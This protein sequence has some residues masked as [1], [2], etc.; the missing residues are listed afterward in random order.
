MP[1]DATPTDAAK[2]PSPLALVAL[3]LL[4][5]IRI[6]EQPLT[7]IGAIGALLI[8]IGVM[9]GRF[10]K[11]TGWERR[12]LP[13]SLSVVLWLSAAAVAVVIPFVM[14]ASQPTLRSTYTPDQFATAP[15]IASQRGFYG[16]ESDPAGNRYAWTQG[17]ARLVF[18]FLVH[19][20]ITIT[21]DARSAAIAGGPDVPV[22]VQVNGEDVGEFRPDPKNGAFQPFSLTFVPYDWGGQRSEIKLAPQQS[23]TPSKTD[24]R[25]LGTMIARITIDKSEA[26]STVARRIWLVWALPVL[27]A[28]A[29]ALVWAARRGRGALAGYGAIAACLLGVGCAA[30]ALFLLFRVGF[31]EQRTYLVWSLGGAF[32][33]GCFAAAALALPLGGPEAASVLQR[34]RARIARSRLGRYGARLKA[35]AALPP[36]AADERPATGRL[37]VRDLLVLFVVAFGLRCVWAVVVPPW[38]APDEPDQFTYVTHLAEQH[39]IPHAPYPNYPAYSKENTT[40]WDLTLLTR[41]SSLGSS[42]THALP[43]YPIAYNYQDARIYRG[44][45]QDRRSAAAGRASSNPPLYYLYSTPVYLLFNGAPILSRLFAVRIGSAVLGALSCVFGY[46]LAYELRRTRRWGW[47]LGLCMALMPM[48]V[49]ITSTVNNDVAM[50]ACAAALIWLTARVYRRRTFS[51]RLALAL[52]ITSGLT[53]LTK[54]TVAPVVA[55][56]GIVVLVKIVPALRS[57]LGAVRARVVALGAYAASAVAVYG[58]WALFNFHYNHVIGFGTIPMPMPAFVRFLGGGAVAAATFPPA[59]G[60]VGSLPAA[61]SFAAI[62]LWQYLQI[63]RHR[64][65]PYFDAVLIKSFWGNFGWLDAP[66]PERAFIPIIIVYIVGGIGLLV[67]LALQP[68]RR[69]IIAL[70]LVFIL[71]QALFL[72]I[73]VDYFHGYFHTGSEFGLQGRYF[74]PVIAPFLFLLLS[75]WD[76][77]CVEHPIALRLAPVG[78]AVLQGIALATVLLRYY[79]VAIG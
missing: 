60:G 12:A 47:S 4:I 70:M 21:F 57:S 2:R 8:L 66:L 23:F 26:W 61:P 34:A 74:F 77:L 11:K 44:A 22:F 79:G 19:K 54:P 50:D 69:G 28:L 71:G 29:C 35:A 25:T 9:I 38:Q 40:S 5:L 73:G 78:M 36:R 63:E 55:V 17:S 67:Q 45:D 33:G 20:P 51:P 16:I 3:L 52:G 49:F 24:P 39:D 32:V 59:S 42:A 48:Y 46:L 62:S 31:V 15:G 56:A 64:G 1:P 37:I 41:L 6:A 75:G 30:A 18:D 72:F 27:A 65:W 58:P 14:L 53:L 76:H 10:L 43:Y 7:R 68:G 13:F